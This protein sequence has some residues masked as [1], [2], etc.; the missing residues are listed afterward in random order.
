MKRNTVPFI[1]AMS[2]ATL[3]SSCSKSPSDPKE[4]SEEVLQTFIEGDY[5]AFLEMTVV[6]LSESQF[7]GI[8]EDFVEGKILHLENKLKDANEDEKKELK[9]NI[10][11]LKKDLEDEIGFKISSKSLFLRNSFQDM[12]FEDWKETMQEV[13]KFEIEKLEKEIRENP[14][15]GEDYRKESLKE[16]KTVSFDSEEFNAWKE[17]KNREKDRWKESFD[18]IVKEAKSAGI[19]WEDVK[20]EYIDCDE[21]RFAYDDADI[22]LVFSY[23][24]KNFKIELD[25]CIRTNLGMLMADQPRW[26]GAF[27]EK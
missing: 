4:F 3:A 11:E 7:E 25:D 14:R 12:E 15:E 19:N 13:N 26:R 20:F 10:D 18:S 21:E 6:D 22:L 27:E 5:D 24:E 1:L 16:M 2:I 8:L 9:K 17:R 23:R